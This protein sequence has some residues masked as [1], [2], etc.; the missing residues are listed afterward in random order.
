M[1]MP[2][3]LHAQRTPSQQP[4]FGGSLVFTGHGEGEVYKATAGFSKSPCCA[5]CRKTAFIFPKFGV[6][7]C[8]C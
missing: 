3:S 5:D 2:Y 8:L 4:Y 7:G 1:G 6:R